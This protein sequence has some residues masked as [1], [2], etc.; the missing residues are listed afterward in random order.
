MITGRDFVFLSSLDFG[1]VWGSREVYATALAEAGNRVF[2]VNPHYG[3]EHLLRRAWIRAAR[4]RQKRPIYEAKKN[5]FVVTPPLAVPGGRYGKILDAFNQGR[6]AGFL[7]AVLDEHGT[8]DPILWIYPPW[9]ERVVGRLGEAHAV[10]FCIDRFSAASRGRK[11]KRIDEAERALAARV[12]GVVSITAHLRDHLDAIRPDATPHLFLPNGAPVEAIESSLAAARKAGGLPERIAKIPSPRLG[13]MGSV[14][15]KVDLELVCDVAAKRPDWHWAFVGLVLEEDL[16]PRTWAQA[17]SLSNL[18]FL[19]AVAR[20]DVASY[21][22][23]FDIATIPLRLNEWTVNV[24]PLKFPEYL[25]L[26]RPIVSTTLPE[27]DDYLDLVHFA[28]TPDEWI[29]EISRILAGE[30]IASPERLRAAARD[31]S[32]TSRTA[33]LSE[34]LG[35]LGVV[36]R[37]GRGPFEDA[38]RRRPEPRR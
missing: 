1:T 27:L 37:T 34:W 2:F 33:R 22:A 30:T 4:A 24:R 38:R 21:E 28:R 29:R 8:K 23:A 6:L 9:T 17:L 5:L 15:A 3:P 14:N 11:R 25:A 20:E 13:F 31:L 19:G 18:H 26:G 36:S 32:W 16:P 10:Y 12:D 35:E 7:R